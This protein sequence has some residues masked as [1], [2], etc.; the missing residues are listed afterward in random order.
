MRP[1]R[2]AGEGHELIPLREADPMS[3]DHRRPAHRGI[4][5]HVI[6]T[7]RAYIA[8][9]ETDTT[10]KPETLIPEDA[11]VAWC[12]AVKRAAQPVGIVYARHLDIAPQLCR[13]RLRA[14]ERLVCQFW[15]SLEEACLSR[16]AT[17]DD[18]VSGLHAREAF[19]RLAEQSLS[20]SYALDEPVAV[21]VIALETPP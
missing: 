3:D 12:F 18:P 21:G 11:S 10:Y 16:S 9:D 8:G 7:G 5:G 17:Q 2:L 14:F 15:V 6:A 1:Y 13:D 20:E 19:L 4:I